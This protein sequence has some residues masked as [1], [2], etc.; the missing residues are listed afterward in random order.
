MSVFERNILKV[1]VGGR[2]FIT[3]RLKIQTKTRTIF[4]PLSYFSRTLGQ[5]TRITEYLGFKFRFHSQKKKRK[6]KQERIQDLENA[7]FCLFALD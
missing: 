7:V 4:K 1:C 6:E 5:R 3:V 2:Y